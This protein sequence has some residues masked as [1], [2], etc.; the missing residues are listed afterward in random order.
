MKNKV[1]LENFDP[2]K[3]KDGSGVRRLLLKAILLDKGVSYNGRTSKDS[4]YLP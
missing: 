3:Q 1:G 2:L 4:R